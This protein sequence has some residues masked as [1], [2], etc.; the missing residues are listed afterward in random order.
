MPNKYT[1][2][3]RVFIRLFQ[4]EDTELQRHARI[5]LFLSQIE[6]VEEYKH[7]DL[8]PTKKGGSLV[9]ITYMDSLNVMVIEY[10]FAKLCKLVREARQNAHLSNFLNLKQ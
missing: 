2:D 10:D 6:S 4:D 5:F 7:T 9:Y 3:G 1:G 8:V